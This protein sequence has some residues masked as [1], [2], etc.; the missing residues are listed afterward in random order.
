[1]PMAEEM[2]PTGAD[3][4]DRTC[5][6]RDI[7]KGKKRYQEQHQEQRIW[8]RAY[9]HEEPDGHRCSDE[10]Q[11]RSWTPAEPVGNSGHSELSEKTA[12]AE[13][14]RHE[15]HLSWRQL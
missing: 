5:N 3:S 2:R 15:S 8:S 4:V 10:G 13:S 14:R 1:M 9:A 12:K 11:H 7:A 6:Q